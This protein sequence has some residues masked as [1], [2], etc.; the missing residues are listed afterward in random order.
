M[1][2]LFPISALCVAG[3]AAAVLAQGDARFAD[4]AETRAALASA[5]EQARNAGARAAELEVE[6]RG[7][8]AA[9]EKTAREAAALAARIQQTEAQIAAA[10]ARS[11]IAR[12]EQDRLEKRLAARQGPLLRLTA[13]L[14]KLARRPLAVAVLRPGSLRETVYLRAMLET[15]LPEVRRRTSAL[16][17]EIDRARAIESEAL[18]AYSALKSGERQ[19]AERRTRLAALETRQRL[20]SRRAGGAAAREAERAL[21]LAEEARDLD[22]LVD[23]L[24]AAGSL[25]KELAALPGPLL[26]PPRP[27]AS[28]VLI[29]SSPP[30]SLVSTAA[31]R[32]L[33]PVAGRTVTGFGAVDDGGA[34]SRGIAL[35]PAAGAQVISPAAGRVAFAGPFSGFGRIV[36]IEH[37][38]GYTSLVTGLARTDVDVGEELVR[39]SP[40]GVAGGRSPVVGFEL[41]RAG[42]PVNPVEY[43]R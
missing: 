34:R 32:F 43:V 6:A 3:L 24:D 16:R 27:G 38:G 13:G 36:I 26:R 15:T 11:L 8:R 14:Q 1:R 18:A 19:L 22:G 2:H 41:R 29:D 39:G 5:R 17:G 9:A 21:A 23:R 40:L 33:I 35:A 37:A 25:R 28:E 4:A 42:E 30:P 31:P 7:T 10:R 20:A 12:A